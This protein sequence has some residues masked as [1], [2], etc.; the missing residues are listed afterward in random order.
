MNDKL[1]ILVERFLNKE[2]DEISIEQEDL[3]NRIESK[4]NFQNLPNETHLYFL[5]KD[6]IL[7]AGN[8]IRPKI[9]TIEAKAIIFAAPM[10]VLSFIYEFSLLA[11]NKARE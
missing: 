8:P 7:A 4:L 2:I 10:E 9:N 1:E 5:A 6:A 3:I 11:V